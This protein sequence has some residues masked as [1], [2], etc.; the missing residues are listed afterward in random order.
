MTT[1]V[2]KRIVRHY[3]FSTVITVEK[4]IVPKKK[5]YHC[6][7]AYNAMQFL[8]TSKR[9][10]ASVSFS[11]ESCKRRKKE[12]KMDPVSCLNRVL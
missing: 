3:Y 8:G 11:E 7:V 10:G 1:E 12:E 6:F 2:C 5:M 9:E 4:V